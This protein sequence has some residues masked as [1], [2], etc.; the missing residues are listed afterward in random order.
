MTT[1]MY[2]KLFHGRKDPSSDMEDWGFQGPTFEVGR[3]VQGTYGCDLKFDT[4]RNDGSGHR[5]EYVDDVIY[6]DN[7]F[8]RDFS[9]FLADDDDIKEGALAHL[10]EFDSVKADPTENNKDDTMPADEPQFIFGPD[11]DGE[12]CLW[13]MRKAA[14]DGTPTDDDGSDLEYVGPVLLR[15]KWCNAPIFPNGLCE[16]ETCPFSVHR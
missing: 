6:Y 7:C 16:A 13:T 10:V 15:C 2:L 1:K 12:Y 5:L 11:S 8:Y 14:Q 3:F 9:V 4:P